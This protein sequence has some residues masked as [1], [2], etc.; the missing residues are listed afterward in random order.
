MSCG[1]PA[2]FQILAFDGG[3]L[4]GLY[5]AAILAEIE[6]QLHVT[7]ADHFDLI[8]GTS[9][10]G[11][12]ALALGA[13]LRPAEIVDF[14]EKHGATIFG[15]PRRL[16]RLCRPK[17]DAD[18]LESPLVEILG[19][20]LLGESTKRLVIPSYSLDLNGVHVFKTRH[21]ARLTRDHTQRMLDVAMATTATPTYLRA[22]R[23]G[24]QHLID[25]GIWANN[26]TVVAVAE[27]KSMLEVPLEAMHVLSIGTTD[28]VT[29]LPPRLHNGGY[30]QWARPAIDTILRAQAVGSFG[31]ARHLVGD[32]HI[33]RVDEPVP[34]GVFQLDRLDADRM[35][36]RAE[37][38]S[39]HVCPLI[40]PFTAHR[41]PPFTPIP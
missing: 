15:K 27:A 25:G 20:R 10:G 1:N 19:E 31:V 9:T 34:K 24:N 8:A 39:R 26:P 41:A 36:G 23:L 4:K 32:D 22:R 5:A 3:G 6:D 40:E 17:H 33:T 29:D 2:R 13:G 30:R 35:R 37:G 38:R 18:R 21:H 12:I 14:Y 7:I 16:R 11:L 28:E